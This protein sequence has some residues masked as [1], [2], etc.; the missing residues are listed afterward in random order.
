MK[1]L[2]AAALLAA[3][4]VA[5][6]QAPAAPVAVQGAWARA[7]MPG[8]ASSAAYMT[9]VAREPLTLTGAVSP[10]AGIIEIHE[11]RMEGDVMKMRAA[12]TL[13]LP[14]GR[15]VELKPGGYHLMLMDLKN[16]M[17][18]D[19]RVPLTLQFRDAAGQPRVLE[20]SVPV[21]Q[22]APMRHKH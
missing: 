5:H 6:A 10:A 3:H 2:V 12:D 18:A 1:K 7:L 19:T 14:P 21:M 11:M 22:G 13:A 8:Q 17:R 16:P 15:P 20:V 9:L 4:F